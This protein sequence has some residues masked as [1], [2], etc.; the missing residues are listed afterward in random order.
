MNVKFN[1]SCF[2]VFFSPKLQN[3]LFQHFY[4]EFKKGAS[5]YTLKC[6]GHEK[7]N[8]KWMRKDWKEYL[9]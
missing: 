7:G 6:N 9:I 4:R 2:G 5:A 3:I 1:N 8:L